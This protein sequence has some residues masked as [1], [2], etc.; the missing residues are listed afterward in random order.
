M[1]ALV[2]ILLVNVSSYW[3]T[4]NLDLKVKVVVPLVITNKRKESK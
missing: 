2:L 4:D 3:L 1:K